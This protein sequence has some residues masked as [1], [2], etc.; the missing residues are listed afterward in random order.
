M[1][2]AKKS[3][4]LRRDSETSTAALE[5]NRPPLGLDAS[6]ADEQPRIDERGERTLRP[7]LYSTTETKHLLNISHATLYR[8][9]ADG[10]LESV[11]IGTSRRI[12]TSSIDRV[13]AGGA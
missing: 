4:D 1:T 12:K 8:M 2:M 10:R 3:P 13:A 5:T 6:T 11:L 9:L 7:L